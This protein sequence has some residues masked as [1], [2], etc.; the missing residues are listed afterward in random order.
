MILKGWW[1]GGGCIPNLPVVVSYAFVRF[2]FK[3]NPH[4]KFPVTNPWTSLLLGSPQERFFFRHVTC[5]STPVLQPGYLSRFACSVV[6]PQMVVKNDDESHGI[7]IRI[8]KKKKQKN[9]NTDGI[10]TSILHPSNF[11]T[12]SPKFISAYGSSGW[13]SSSPR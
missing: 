8:R 13:R 12:K 11:F 7:R 4:L 6:I 2:F 9:A 3:K 5:D 1:G 10:S